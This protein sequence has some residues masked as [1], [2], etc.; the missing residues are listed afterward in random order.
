MPMLVGELGPEIILPN[1]S[2]TVIPN[3]EIQWAATVI[4][5]DAIAELTPNLRGISNE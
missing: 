5:M 3:S 4:Y 2:G 1:T